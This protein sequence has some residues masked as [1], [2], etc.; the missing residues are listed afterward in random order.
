MP[1]AVPL[2]VPETLNVAPEPI[3]ITGEFAIE[4]EPDKANVPAE[5]VVL[6]E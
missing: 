4:P 3:D 2:V 1:S 6:P 5:M